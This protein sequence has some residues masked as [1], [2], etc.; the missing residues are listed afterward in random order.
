MAEI[1]TAERWLYG[2]L[3]N[4]ATLTGLASGGVYTWPVPAGITLPYVLY[5]N[6]TGTDIRGTGA[7]R[8][9]V[10][11]L[12]IVR[13]IAET[14]SFGGNLQSAADR[15]DALL[16]GKA[17]AVTGGVVWACVRTEPFQ[18]VEMADGRQFRHLGGIY[19]IYVQ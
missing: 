12:W 11:G 6:Q 18:L 3:K 5:Q 1:V 9:G 17:S 15:I 2:K 10:N 19:R 7:T 4:D 13:A 8:I 14:Y 16:H